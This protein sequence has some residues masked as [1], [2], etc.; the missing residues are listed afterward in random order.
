[1]GAMPLLAVHDRALDV[2][3]VYDRK[4]WADP[5]LFTVKDGQLVDINTRS[6]WDPR[7]GKAIAGNMKGSDMK[8]YY[9]VYSMWFAWYSINPETLYIPG[10]GEVPASMLSTDV[11][12]ADD[13]P[14][15]PPPQGPGELPG[16]PSWG[17]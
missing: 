3:R 11:P 2:V 5:F 17:N 16:A 12:G 8:Q 10:P 14:G 1:M 15:P 7:T 9:G 6:I 4:I 13:L